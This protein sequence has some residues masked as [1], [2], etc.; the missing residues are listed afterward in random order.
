MPVRV[1]RRFAWVLS[2]YGTAQVILGSVIPPAATMVTAVLAHSAANVHGYPL[3][4][5]VGA[6]FVLALVAIILFALAKAP[7]PLSVVQRGNGTYE[8]IWDEEGTEFYGYFVVTNP[9]PGERIQVVNINVD[10][11][12]TKS[13]LL[14]RKLH[15]GLAEVQFRDGQ[16]ASLRL[17]GARPSTTDARL[18]FETPYWQ[19]GDYRG[20]I[21][22]GFTLVDQMGRKHRASGAFVPVV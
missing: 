15:G 2:V 17:G 22:V 11:C 8:P 6:V 18:R 21:L 5:L 19:R 10:K 3:L 20:K 4:A 1:I 12:C 13:G 16:G 7:R 14:W 9:E